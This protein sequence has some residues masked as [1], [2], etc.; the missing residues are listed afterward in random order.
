MAWSPAGAEGTIRAFL[1]PRMAAPCLDGVT[2]PATTGS[3]GTA[4]G[5]WL[6]PRIVVMSGTPALERGALVAPRHW[7]KMQGAVFHPAPPGC[8]SVLL[9]I[10]PGVGWWGHG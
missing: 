1:P 10:S 7:V 2:S 9:G 3:V 6:S 4:R 5:E 8:P